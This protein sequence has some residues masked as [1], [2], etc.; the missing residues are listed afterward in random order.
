MLV[1]RSL[2][3]RRDRKLRNDDQS[4]MCDCSR[5]R[6]TR[7]VNRDGSTEPLVMYSSRR[8]VRLLISKR[9]T[10]VNRRCINWVAQLGSLAQSP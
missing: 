8:L 5:R 3:I 9:P 10:N 6:H 4:V 2:R 1:L 7:F